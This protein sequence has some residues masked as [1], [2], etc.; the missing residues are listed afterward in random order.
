MEEEGKGTGGGGGSER[1]SEGRGGAGGQGGGARGGEWVVK[2]VVDSLP[3][4]VRNY[5]FSCIFPG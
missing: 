1:G 3:I 5:F 4:H 2:S